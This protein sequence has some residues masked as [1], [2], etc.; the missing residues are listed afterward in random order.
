VDFETGFRTITAI[1]DVELVISRKHTKYFAL[2]DV[3][4]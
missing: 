3:L 2:T 4:N 1:L